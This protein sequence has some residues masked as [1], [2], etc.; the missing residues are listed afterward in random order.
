MVNERRE[1]KIEMLI[2]IYYLS[3]LLASKIKSSI[4]LLKLR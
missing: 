4:F 1:K 2:A 3:R